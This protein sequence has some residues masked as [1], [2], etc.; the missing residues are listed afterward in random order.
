M[1]EEI[2][3]LTRA[4]VCKAINCSSRKLGYMLAKKD[5]P[6]GF[7]AG[8]NDRWS[9]QA[10]SNWYKTQFAEQEAWRPIQTR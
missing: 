3:T 5:F 10:V 6:K 7:G 2:D 8:K 9:K 4:E 1:N